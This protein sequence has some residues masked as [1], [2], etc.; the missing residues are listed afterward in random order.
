[1]VTILREADERPVPEM[2]KKHG[3]SAQTILRVTETLRYAGSPGHQAAAPL[4]ARKRSP[5]EDGGRPRPRERRPQGDHPK[6]MVGAR[7]R[8]QQV[9]YAQ[10][11]G[12]SSRRACALLS[13]AR[14]T[15]GYASRLVCATHRPWHAR[16]GRSESALRLS[17]DPD[18]PQ[19]RGPCDERE[20]DAVALAPSA[21]A[22]AAAASASPSGDRPPTT[23]AGLRR[24]SRVGI[25]LRVRHVREWGAAAVS[26]RDRRMDAGILGDLTCWAFFGPA[27]A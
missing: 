5:E 4:G 8:Q 26:D 23:R 13:V 27:E 20:S 17:T 1:M 14:S 25:R 10:G 19:A 11:R 3:V 24:E 16:A 9:A 22:G 7:A 15:L 21:A 18:L 12:L 2:A 6:E